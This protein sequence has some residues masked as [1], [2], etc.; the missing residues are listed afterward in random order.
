MPTR[1]IFFHTSLAEQM[2]FYGFATIAMAV[3]SFGFFRRYVGWMQGRRIDPIKDW[4][5]RARWLFEQVA[6]QKR[7]RRRNYA[8][9]MHMLIF[10]GMDV[11]FLGTCI[12]AVEHYGALVCG[13][14][15]FYRGAF[16]L[17]CK[18]LLDLFGLGVLVGT[19]MALGRRWF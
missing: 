16:Y 10:Y 1:T 2:L 13:D 7:T 6:A 11:L 3:C 18:V 15:W 9:K 19:G 5:A 14:H 17:L 12:V 4:S 8:G